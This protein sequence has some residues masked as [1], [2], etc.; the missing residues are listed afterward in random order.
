MSKNED[1]IDDLRIRAGVTLEIIK[2]LVN[3]R[4]I[5]LYDSEKQQTYH[6]YRDGTRKY[7]N[8]NQLLGI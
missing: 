4:P 3:G 7:L 5:A 1:E 2:T 8:D 6:L